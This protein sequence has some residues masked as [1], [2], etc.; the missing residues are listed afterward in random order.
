M[1]L[2]VFT[3]GGA[4]GNPG[5]AAIGIVVYHNNEAV[6]KHRED[7]GEATNNVAEYT[8]LVKAYELL[9]KD[10]S[11]FISHA[12]KVEFFS[13]SQLMVNQLNGMYKVKNARIREFIVAIKI[14]EQEIG[15]PV[16][17]TY[18]P[19]EENTVADLLVNDKLN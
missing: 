19:R 3:D 13:D 17:Y 18:V 11:N 16:S 5:P 6:L 2:K 1:T 15:I 14:A 4:K 8:A 12:S 10:T 7:I 9:K